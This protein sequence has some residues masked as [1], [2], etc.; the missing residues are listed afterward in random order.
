MKK[1][2]IP[3]EVEK[4]GCIDFYAGFMDTLWSILWGDVIENIKDIDVFSLFSIDD[5]TKFP[6]ETRYC[7]SLSLTEIP[8]ALRYCSEVFSQMG[9][10]EPGMRHSR[11]CVGK[12]DYQWVFV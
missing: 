10:S 7:W 11:Q 6:E 2:T 3:L 4:R 9:N 8:S 12:L 1:K 5:I